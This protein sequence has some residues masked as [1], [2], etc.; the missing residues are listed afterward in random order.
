VCCSVFQF[1]SQCVLQYV[2][3]RVALCV[4]VCVAMRVA[5]TPAIL[6]GRHKLN[7]LRKATKTTQRPIDIIRLA[8]GGHDLFDFFKFGTLHYTHVCMIECVCA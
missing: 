3:V 5:V 4:A 2:A 7:L 1:A 8:R 6:I